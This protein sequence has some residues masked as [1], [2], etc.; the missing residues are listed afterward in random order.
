MLHAPQSNGKLER[1]HRTIKAD[2][3]RPGTSLSLED[4]RR[5]VDKFVRH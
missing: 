5:L 1:F 4:A 3:M 2:C